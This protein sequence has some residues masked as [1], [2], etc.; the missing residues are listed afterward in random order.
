M[1]NKPIKSKMFGC[2]N[3]SYDASVLKQEELI[4]DSMHNYSII[5]EDGCDLKFNTYEDECFKYRKLSEV[6][7]IAMESSYKS[8][9]IELMTPLHDETWELNKEDGK[10]YLVKQGPGYA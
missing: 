1:K 3:C 5:L 2:G 7:K 8:F 6:T 9:V 4:M 10:W